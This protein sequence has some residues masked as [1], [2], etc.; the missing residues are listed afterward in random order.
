MSQRNKQKSYALKYSPTPVTSSLQIPL[1]LIWI[2][3]IFEQEK[4]PKPKPNKVYKNQIPRLIPSSKCICPSILSP[5][6][7]QGRGSPQERGSWEWL[8]E[9]E[10]KSAFTLRL[11]ISWQVVK[12]TNYSCDA[13]S[14]T[15]WH[16]RE[17]LPYE[18]LCMSLWQVF[19]QKEKDTR[20]FPQGGAQRNTGDLGVLW[21]AFYL[22]CPGLSESCK[23]QPL[24]RFNSRSWMNY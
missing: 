11:D 14:E 8:Q 5:G 16:F 18:I 17:K 23:K 13:V 24:V 21:L 6:F 10:L 22:L 20:S 4:K 9:T 7:Q 3:I 15:S 1:K 19:H 2:F 12:V